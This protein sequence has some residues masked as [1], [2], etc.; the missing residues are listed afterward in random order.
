MEALLLFIKGHLSFRE[1]R[2]VTLGASPSFI[3]GQLV[4]LGASSSFG[5]AGVPA[6]RCIACQVSGHS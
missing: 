5:E 3:E 6:L 4:T 2:P 1:A